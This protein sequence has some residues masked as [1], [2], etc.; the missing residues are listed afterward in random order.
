MSLMKFMMKCVGDKMKECIQE[1]SGQDGEVATLECE[2]CWDENYSQYTSYGAGNSD[3][4]K[5]E[6]GN[7]KVVSHILYGFDNCSACRI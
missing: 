5:K 1:C 7:C 6:C 2:R 3:M 4:I